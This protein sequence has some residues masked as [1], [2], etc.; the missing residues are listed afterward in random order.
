M[1]L[2]PRRS[3]AARRPGRPHGG[4]GFLPDSAG[5]QPCASLKLGL[6][7]AGADATGLAASLDVRGSLTPEVDS[8][9][10]LVLG[11]LRPVGMAL[12]PRDRARRDRRLAPLAARAAR[13]SAI[14]ALG[15][16]VAVF[17]E[18]LADAG[19][20]VALSGR[21]AVRFDLGVASLLAGASSTRPRK[22]ALRAPA[23][24]L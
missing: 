23:R 21:P 14:V 7:D 20:E 24:A 6:R 3:R 5:R 9:V 12:A 1:G 4:R 2:T 8:E 17:A 16:R 18:V 22:L 11:A 19:G 15:Q 13:R 10:A